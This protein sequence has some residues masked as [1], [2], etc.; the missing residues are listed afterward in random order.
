MVKCGGVVWWNGVKSSEVKWSRV[1]SSGVEV[2]S[3]G[4]ECGV[5]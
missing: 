2:D 1:E 4:V 3:R 5:E